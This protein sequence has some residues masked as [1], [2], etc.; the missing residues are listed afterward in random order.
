MGSR[1]EFGTTW[2]SEEDVFPPQYVSALLFTVFNKSDTWN[3]LLLSPAST[4]LT[5]GSKPVMS[6]HGYVYK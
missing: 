2:S 3:H 5:S 4:S 6:P 1:E